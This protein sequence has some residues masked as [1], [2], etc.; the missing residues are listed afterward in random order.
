MLRL[1]GLLLITSGTLL[2]QAG[3]PPTG[4]APAGP[5]Q[6]AAQGPAAPRMRPFS[7]VTRGAEHRPGFFETYQK[8]DK[9]WIVVPAERFGTDFLMEMKIAQGIGANGLYGGLMLNLT[10][11]NI[12]T[13]ERRGE[14]VFLLQKPHRDRSSR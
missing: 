1:S 9:V 6:G 8:D 13:I 10:E 2:A 3:P 7:E 11:A 14:Q 5:P 12:M 4:G